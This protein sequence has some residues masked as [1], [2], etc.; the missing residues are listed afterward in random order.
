MESSGLSL[1][2][3]LST[4]T[5]HVAM[6][7]S[8]ITGSGKSNKMLL[9]GGGTFNKHL[10]TRIRHYSLPLIVIPDDL[11][12]NFKEALIF[13]FLGVLRWRNEA[14]CLSSVTGATK[15]NSGGCIYLS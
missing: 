3:Q 14:N 2:D 4:F 5:E 1:Q 12:I 6:Q 15:D 10:I 9:T 11:T 7:I 13:A 8:R